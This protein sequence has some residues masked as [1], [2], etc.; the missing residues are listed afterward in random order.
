MSKMI[1]QDIKN[2]RISFIKIIANIVITILLMEGSFVITS[3][4]SPV[5]RSLFAVSI[6]ILGTVYCFRFI[7][8][9]LAYYTYRVI[10]DEIILERAIGRAN[11]LVYTIKKDEILK[12]EKYNGQKGVNHKFYRSKSSLYFIEFMFKGE[13]IGIV[14]E[15][16]NE[17]IEEIN[18]ILKD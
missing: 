7:Y 3:N 17:M 2:E 12:F 4:F 5:M 6:L 16:N 14:F 10:D 8:R 18:D 13:D 15:P 9:D 11:Y 1:K